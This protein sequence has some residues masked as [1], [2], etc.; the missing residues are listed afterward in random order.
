MIHKLINK[1]TLSNAFIFLTTITI[2]LIVFHI[3]Q[4][5]KVNSLSVILNTILN[6]YFLLAFVVYSILML[7][8]IKI[9]KFALESIFNAF[10]KL[11][12]EDPSL[13]ITYINKKQLFYTF[14]AV[15]IAKLYGQIISKVVET[16]SHFAPTLESYLTSGKY[17]HQVLHSLDLSTIVT[18]RL[19][20][21][22]VISIISTV[23]STMYL[24]YVKKLRIVHY[25]VI[26]P[27]TAVIR[28][29]P[30]VS[31]LYFLY[32]VFTTVL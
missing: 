24:S 23:G 7:G 3:L 25:E 29:I 4:N 30:Y 16:I 31:Y 11:I 26:E 13:I 15:L 8:Y 21:L 17:P 12:G 2:A 22:G 1:K 9:V 20:L 28:I 5:P 14:I 10:I 27:T 6:K 19:L 32:V 18:N